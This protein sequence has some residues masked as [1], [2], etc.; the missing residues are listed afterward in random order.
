MALALTQASAQTIDLILLNHAGPGRAV[1]IHEPEVEALLGKSV[2]ALPSVWN[3]PVRPGLFCLPPHEARQWSRTPD[4]LLARYLRAVRDRRMS[5]AVFWIFPEAP[6]PPQRRLLINLTQQLKRRGVEIGTVSEPNVALE[7]AFAL[8]ARRAGAFLAALSVPLTAVWAGLGPIGAFCAALGGGSAAW[9]LL[10]TDAFRYQLQG[11]HFVT[12]VFALPFVVLILR[13]RRRGQFFSVSEVLI[14]TLV[15]VALLRLKMF[16]PVT[17][18]EHAIRDW[19]EVAI[20]LRPRVAETTGWFFFALAGQVTGVRKKEAQAWR[21]FGLFGPIVTM[22]SFLHAHTPIDRIV[23]RSLLG[24][25]IGYIFS[26]MII[27]LRGGRSTAQA[28]LSS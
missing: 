18:L 9:A 27:K 16:L 24:F 12:L 22:N 3:C 15:A 4:S 1:S 17:S 13:Q 21:A 28:V 5:S 8:W 23:L 20:G 10:Q 7:P 14:L 2:S 11:L 26:F 25:L 19:M 6:W